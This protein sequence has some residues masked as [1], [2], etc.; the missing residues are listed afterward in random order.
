MRQPGVSFATALH[1]F[2][3]ILGGLGGVRS[4]NA[5]AAST[6]AFEPSL[7]VV[8]QTFHKLKLPPNVVQITKTKRDNTLDLTAINNITGGGYYA[9][10]T[11]GTPPQQIVMHLDTGSSDTWVVAAGA[12]FCG[13]DALQRQYGYCTD[14]FD[15][16]ASDSYETAVPG[17]F[18]I[19]YLDGNRVRGDYF[20]DRISVGGQTIESQQMGLGTD[21][22]RPSGL[23]GLGLSDFVAANRP[24]ATVLENMVAQ[25]YIGRAAYSVW[26]NDLSADEGEILF[27][28]ID[29]SRYYGRL[30]TL[31]IIPTFD[32]TTRSHYTVSL[33]SISIRNSTDADPELITPSTFGGRAILDTGSTLSLLPSDVAESIFSA[34][35]I[36]NNYGVAL[37]DCE[38]AGSQGDG[39]ALDFAFDDDGPAVT[40]RVPMR[41]M[42]LD[43]IG[44]ASLAG[45]NLPFDDACVFGIQDTALFGVTAEN[46]GDGFV[47]LGDTFLRSA[48]V[49]YDE[50]NMQVGIAQAVLG[51]DVSADSSG[52]IVELASG[53]RSIPTA[54]GVDPSRASDNIVNHDEDDG[55]DD[56]AAGRIGEGGMAGMGVVGA[57]VLLA[58]SVVVL[59]AVL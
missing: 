44:S 41:E 30:T 53:Q 46:G 38:L 31:P 48:Y 8:S 20:T 34:F 25:G 49:V 59:T 23:M 2:S 56:N 27:G 14:T 54:T 15:P 51:D 13:S 45:T 26:M 32:G 57:S 55:D 10:V 40:I 4:A 37:V 22:Q 52:D 39:I 18:S 43:I 58:S 3:I 42:V 7:K 36:D 12:D 5:A 17:G 9:E 33:G 29:T 35:G 11:V 47:L 16:D 6:S 21:L 1:G 24:Y 19:Q 28:G 50:P